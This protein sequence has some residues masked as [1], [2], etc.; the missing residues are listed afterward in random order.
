MKLYKIEKG[1][2][3]PPILRA[4]SNGKSSA[5]VATVQCLKRGES[6]LVKDP[7]D[8]VKASKAL[9][10]FMRRERSTDGKRAF[11]SRKIGAGLRIWR[12]R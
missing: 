2:E 12:V 8:A 7:L 1:I 10:D 5:V 3:I 9:R 11:I 6:F 4:G